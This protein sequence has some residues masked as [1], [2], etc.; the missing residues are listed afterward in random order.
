VAL[1]SRQTALFNTSNSSL[2][3]S[4]ICGSS[5]YKDDVSEIDASVIGSIFQEKELADQ[6]A[7]KVQLSETIGRPSLP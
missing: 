5:W 7:M 4:Y 2:V 6:S 3:Y 1:Q